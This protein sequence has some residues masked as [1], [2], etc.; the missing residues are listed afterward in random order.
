M[1]EE[2]FDL[3]VGR[4]GPDKL[5]T[6]FSKTPFWLWVSHCRYSSNQRCTAAW[7]LGSQAPV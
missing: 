4:R 2:G 3:K 6:T 1:K 7:S 5:L